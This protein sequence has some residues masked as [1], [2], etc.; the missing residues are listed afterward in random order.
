MNNLLLKGIL[1]Q[2]QPPVPTDY[3]FGDN[4]PNATR[5]YSLRQLSA[6]ITEIIEI[7]RSSDNT[8][9]YF[10]ESEISDGT[11]EA[12]VGAGNDGLVITWVDQTGNGLDLHPIATTEPLL[13]ESGSLILSNGLPAIKFDGVNNR[14]IGATTNTGVPDAAILGVFD[15]ENNGTLQYI[16]GYGRGFT[17]S[18]D[19][20][21]A[22]NLVSQSSNPTARPHI[23]YS[24][25]SADKRHIF[26]TTYIPK[27]VT[28]FH[29]RNLASEMSH[30]LDIHTYTGENYDIQN[31]SVEFA[32][33]FDVSRIAFPMKGTFQEM[34]F[35]ATDQ[36][37]NRAGMKSNINSYY[38]IY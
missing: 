37:A 17:A 16:G 21:N 26:T 29:R 15:N 33:G 3:F 12:W 14:L 8:T 13:V 32:I 36:Y 10:T 18:S 2:Q 19:A 31:N 24:G 11:L 22:I 7:K 5:A 38:D 27:L 25:V 9:S 34:I 30:N 35:Y 23:K 6:G 20:R 1:Q 28:A 4:F